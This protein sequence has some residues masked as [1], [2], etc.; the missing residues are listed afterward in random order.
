MNEDFNSIIDQYRADGR[1]DGY[2]ARKIF[3]SGD[4]DG[5]FNDLVNMVSS[6]KKKD[7]ADQEPTQEAPQEQ[8]PT[9]T[10]G[11]MLEGTPSESTPQDKTPDTEPVAAK[12][13][14]V[15]SIDDLGKE[16]QQRYIQ[17]R[18]NALVQLIESDEEFGARVSEIE[19]SDKDDINKNYLVEQAFANRFTEKRRELNEQ[20]K[21]E[22]LG[23]LP[24]G[25]NLKEAASKLYM[26]YGLAVDLDG[27]AA[28]NE[29]VG[30]ISSTVTDWMVKLGSQFAKMAV[31]IGSF[32]GATQLPG[33]FRDNLDLT[34]A[35]SS[36]AIDAIDEFQRVSTTQY[37]QDFTEAITNGDI[38]QALARAGG[39]VA[40]S[41]PYIVGA[42]VSPVGLGVAA[43]TDSYMSSKQEDLK[44]KKARHRSHL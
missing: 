16:Y 5:E 14:R 34:A 35:I 12:I 17:D 42:A 28:Y 27:N 19:A 20:Y 22:I 41:T 8:I 39:F 43:S 11:S 36:E 26:D 30:G 40:E 29:G 9:V 23:K 2:I 25:T 44:R 32:A 18:N 7:P 24:E 38:S 10:M 21:E 31:N 3:L 33:S 15:R 13:N 6:Y 4:Y 37:D 1:D